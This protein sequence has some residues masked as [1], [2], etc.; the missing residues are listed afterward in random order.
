MFRSERWC[1]PTKEVWMSS[2]HRR[3][4]RPMSRVCVLALTPVLAVSALAACGKSTSGGS[5][6]GGTNTKGPSAAPTNDAKYFPGKKATGSPVKIALIV[7][8][9]GTA[10]N[11]PET[12]QAAVAAIKYANDN[13]GGMAGHVIDI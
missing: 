12:G 13:L 9:G 3:S 10:V 7:N 4:S 2:L 5:G 1:S 6:G 11:Q 8:S